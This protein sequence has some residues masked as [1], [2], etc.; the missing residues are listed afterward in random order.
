MKFLLT[1][2]AWHVAKIYFHYTFEQNVFKKF[3]VSNNQKERQNSKFNIER[4]N[5][6]KLINNAKFGVDCRN[7]A[8]NSTF[9]PIVDEVNEIS[10]LKKHYC[11]FD[12][13]ISGFV[14]SEIL[15]KEIKQ[16]YNQ[17]APKV[18]DDDPFKDARIKSLR[19]QKTD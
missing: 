5:I 15:E 3:F 4:L 1:R 17:G 14:N 16:K 13:K 11:T 19:N 8:N 12:N 18:R 10:Y 6:E 9:E 2:C 7:N